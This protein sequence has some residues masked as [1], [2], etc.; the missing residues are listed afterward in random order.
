MTVSTAYIAD[1][2]FDARHLVLASGDLGE[3]VDGCSKALRP[4]DLLMRERRGTLAAR[5]G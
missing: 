3:V 5:A 4:H 1:Q 2:L